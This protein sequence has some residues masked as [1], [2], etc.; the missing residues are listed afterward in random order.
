MQKRIRTRQVI[1]NARVAVFFYCL[2][3]ALQFFSRKI[4][5]DYLGADLLG[6]NTTVQNLLQFLNIAESGMGAAVAATLYKPLS[7]GNRQEI[8]EVISIQGWFY[9][10]VAVI[11]AGGAVIMMMFFPVIFEG[12]NIPLA[13]AYGTFLVFLLNALLGYFINYQIVLLSADQQDYK[14]TIVTQ[15]IRFLKVLTQMVAILCLSEGYV[16]WIIIEG[17]FAVVT[18]FGLHRC[19][20]RNYPWLKVKVS[21][22][23]DCR[24]KYPQ[25]LIK[26]QQVF[27][28]KIASFAIGQL[29]P[30]MVFAFTSLS[31]VATYGNYLIIT[32]GCLMM[33]DAVFRGF[34]SSVG[35]LI[36]ENKIQH[37][38]TVFWEIT[39]LRLVVAFVI[40]SSIFL[41]SDSFIRLWIGDA[42]LLS[43]T[44]V[45][46]I[47]L[48]CF[49][50][51][52]RSSDIFISAYGLFH[53]TWVPIVETLIYTL[54]SFLLGFLWGLT[55]ILVGLLI[56]RLLVTVSWKAYFL[57]KY[58]FKENVINFFIE[59][60]KRF[61]LLIVSFI[62]VYCIVN[63]I[64]THL[65]SLLDWFLYA[66]FI[67]STLS[68]LTC[69]VFLLFDQFFRKLFKR[70]ILLLSHR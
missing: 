50:E 36:V 1:L 22:G 16:W 60:A 28:H 67:V 7:T 31:L 66:T 59:Y 35:N 70:V 53:D 39:S 30:L 43:V 54:L 23:K 40:C 8:N 46:L 2:H 14:V 51:M 20:R 12:A 47:S 34:N 62:F 25:I 44:Q 13:Y 56:I 27:F 26:T 55:G 24:V 45:A 29:T 5:L 19:I 37:I 18:S 64:D 48:I 11:V 9:R 42:Y 65:E 58:G 63:S 4:F 17:F 15:G 6:L 41:L 61:L 32:G 33:V 38:K 10:W 57:F 52:S 49:F 69:T 21:K 3:F 68:A